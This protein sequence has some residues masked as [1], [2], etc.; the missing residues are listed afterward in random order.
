MM[1]RMKTLFQCFLCWNVRTFAIGVIAYGKP[2]VVIALSLGLCAGRIKSLKRFPG[3]SN[4][5]MAE[6]IKEDF[7]D[8]PK[9]LQW[10]VAD[11]LGD[12]KAKRINE[13]RIKGQYLDTYEVVSQIRDLMFHDGMKCAILIA[14]P[15]HAWRAM[16]VCEK[17]GIA[18]LVPNGLERIPFDHLSVQSW[19]R[20]PI[21]FIL[22]EIPARLLY[23]YR[24]WI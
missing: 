5:V 23:W 8:L 22:R 9:I 1:G 17:M 16:K 24:G 7:K 14:H 12:L 4:E 20:G 21:R 3:L 15:L 6:I 11:A 13:H 10:E 19:T 18:T 2:D